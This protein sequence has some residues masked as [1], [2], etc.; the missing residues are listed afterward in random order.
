MKIGVKVEQKRVAVAGAGVAGLSAAI[1][2][3]RAGCRVT[4]F[5]ATSRAGGRARTSNENGFLFNM[6]PHAFYSGGAGH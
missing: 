1:E 6:G 5:E 3:A 4:V 2:A